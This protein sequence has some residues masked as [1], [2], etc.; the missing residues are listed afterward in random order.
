M[1]GLIERF[2][3]IESAGVPT[4]GRRPHIVIVGAGF[5]GLTAAMRLSAP[6]PM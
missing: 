1:D 5:G 2:A 6:R 3:K 4:L